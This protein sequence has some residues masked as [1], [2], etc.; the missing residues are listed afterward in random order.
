MIVLCFG[1]DVCDNPRGFLDGK[2]GDALS[3]LPWFQSRE[4]DEKFSKST[5]STDMRS[6]FHWARYMYCLGRL[7]KRKRSG[8]KNLLAPLLVMLDLSWQSYISLLLKET[9]P[10]NQEFVA[11]CTQRTFSGELFSGMR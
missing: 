4:R 1:L 10:L 8:K 3:G 9:L 2:R 11:L 6:K 5:S 7:Q